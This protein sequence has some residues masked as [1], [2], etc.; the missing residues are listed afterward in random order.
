MQIACKRCDHPNEEGAKF[1]IGCGARLAQQADRLIG[2]TLLDRYT[3]VERIGEGGMGRVYLA[4]QRLGTAT[5]RVAIKTLR[6][7]LSGDAQ[8]VGRFLRECEIVS[9]LNHPNTVQFFDFGELEGGELFIVMEYIEG[10]DL[11]SLIDREGPLELARV[12]RILVQLAGSLHEAHQLGIVHRDLKPDNILLTERALQPDF[13]KVL[14]FGI[15]RHQQEAQ[16]GEARTQLTMQGMVLGTPPYMSPEQFGEGSPDARSD[17]YSLGIILY[18]MLTGRLPF[19][20]K[21][22]WEWANRHLSEPPLQLDELERGRALPAY[23]RRAVMKAL[24]KDPEERQRDVMEL[25]AEFTGAANA[26]ESWLEATQGAFAERSIV[27]ARSDNLPIEEPGDDERSFED[28]EEEELLPPLIEPPQLRRAVLFLAGLLAFVTAGV[29]ALRP[30]I[31]AP[32]E[33]ADGSTP[34]LEMSAHHEDVARRERDASSFGAEEDEQEGA[35]SARGKSV[36]SADPPRRAGRTT[37]KRASTKTATRTAMSAQKAP[38]AISDAPAA[39]PRP[40]LGS[41]MSEEPAARSSSSAV[42]APPDEPS[43][44]RDAPQPATERS[45]EQTPSETS[46][47]A[48]DVD[49]EEASKIA[50]GEALLRDA[51]AAMRGERFKEAASLIRRAGTLLGAGSS[52]YL[53]AQRELGRLGERAVGNALMRG[54]CEEAQALYGLLQEAGAH[55]RAGAQFTG[56]WCPRP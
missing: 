47:A 31:E 55:S 44:A 41:M 23:R 5:R 14:D 18:E 51:R 4:E 1:C 53:E 17:L 9:Q 12:D 46:D 3:I 50:L 24:S 2:Q 11:G 7:E 38:S 35:E 20:A 32:K 26:R 6:T 56:D 33:L 13:V 10:E 54:R 16:G 28:F 43:N 21:T 22:P 48:R 25:L 37:T 42:K 29:F 15:A 52:K 30:F 34:E 39:E 36:K 40:S 49:D 45:R 27:D 8:I 19:E